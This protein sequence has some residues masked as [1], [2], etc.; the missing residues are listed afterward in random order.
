MIERI[1]NRIVE[2]ISKRVER[3]INKCLIV[4]LD[5]FSLI[6][7]AAKKRLHRELDGFAGIIANSNTQIQHYIDLKVSSIERKLEAKED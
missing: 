3:K 2:T 1:V 6:S 5:E 4:E 7:K